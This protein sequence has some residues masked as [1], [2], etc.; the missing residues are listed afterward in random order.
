MH[1]LKKISINTLIFSTL[2]D[3]HEKYYVNLSL[4]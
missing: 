1:L 2:K 3:K 4:F